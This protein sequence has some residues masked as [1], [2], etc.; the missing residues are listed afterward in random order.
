MQNIMNEYIIVLTLILFIIAIVIFIF[1]MGFNLDNKCD[2]WLFVKTFDNVPVFMNSLIS[3]V[4]GAFCSLLFM[5][6]V[7][8]KKNDSSSANKKNLK[9]IEKKSESAETKTSSKSKKLGKDGR[10]GIIAKIRDLNSKE[11]S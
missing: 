10:E 9:T 5:L 8:F 6:L 3:F 11:D 7:R 1:Y 2:I 4:F